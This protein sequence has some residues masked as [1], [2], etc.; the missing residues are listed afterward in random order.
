MQDYLFSNHTHVEDFLAWEGKIYVDMSDKAIVIYNYIYPS[1]SAFRKQ[2]MISIMYKKIENCMTTT[3][4]IP[5]YKK[6]S[7]AH[8]NCRPK[9]KKKKEKKEILPNN[10]GV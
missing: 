8:K 10:A 6:K 7:C 3:T 2:V 5:S 1:K 9:K 4:Y